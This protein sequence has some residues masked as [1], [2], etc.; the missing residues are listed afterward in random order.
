MKWFW[1][2]VPFI[3]FFYKVDRRSQIWAFQYYNAFYCFFSIYFSCFLWR[4][5]FVYVFSLDVMDFFLFEALFPPLFMR[6]TR[7]FDIFLDL[8]YFQWIVFTYYLWIRRIFVEVSVIL[9]QFLH[10]LRNSQ[11]LHSISKFSLRF[12]VHRDFFHSISITHNPL[13][14]K[15]MNWTDWEK[16]YSLFLYS[17]TFPHIS[18]FLL[19]WSN[20]FSILFQKLNLTSN[21]STSDYNM[22]YC[23][24]G[25]LERGYK[26]SNKFQQTHF[27][28]IR[29][30]GPSSKYTKS[31]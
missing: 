13:S 7:S 10:F 20:W 16:S 29:R 15:W 17:F 6:I 22:G 12:P 14:T 3:A 4:W 27:V 11:Y 24:T 23:L 19:Y 9:L 31:P 25:T 2:I 5:S 1:W 18:T 28:V 8:Q 30:R 26:E 21:V